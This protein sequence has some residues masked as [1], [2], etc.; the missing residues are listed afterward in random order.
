MPKSLRIKMVA[1]ARPS[2]VLVIPD[3]GATIGRGEQAEIR[4]EEPT[5]SRQHCCIYRHRKDW[6]VQD[7]DSQN[8][9]FVGNRRVTEP[10]RV[11][12]G[13]PVRFGDAQFTFRG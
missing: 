7:L 12:D 1:G 4:L 9:T 6:L 10:T 3:T 11:N 2:R 5:L 8:G 13:E